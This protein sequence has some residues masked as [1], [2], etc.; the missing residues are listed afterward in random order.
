[1]RY[2]HIIILCVLVCS[3]AKDME[4]ATDVYTF[5]GRVEDFDMRVVLEEG[6]RDFFEGNLN[7]KDYEIE[8]LSKI[9][10]PAI[11]QDIG[12]DIPLEIT[13]A[14]GI[15]ESG[16][17]RSELS[18]K[19]NNYFGIKDYGGGRS[20][21]TR[22]YKNGKFVKVNANFAVYI[23]MYDCMAGRTNWFYGN[24]RYKK[25]LGKDYNWRQWS[26]ILQEK[27]YATDPDYAKK[28]QSIIKRYELDAY[29]SWAR[30]HIFDFAD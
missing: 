1:M 28:L 30:N 19:S 5:R 21:P 8:F 9:A 17:G 3:C 22:E 6:S 18:K 16:W 13:I 29:G 7:L 14:Q 20:Y 4:L 26:V 25:V 11:V 12:H 15:L 2:I 27:G 10:V 24:R 23:D